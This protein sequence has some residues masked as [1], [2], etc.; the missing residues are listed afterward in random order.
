MAGSWAAVRASAWPSVVAEVV[1]RTASWQVAVSHWRWRFFGRR[2]ALRRT[3]AV[4]AT[5][6][7]GGGCSGRWQRPKRRRPALGREKADPTEVAPADA[8]PLQAVNIG[9]P[10][11]SPPAK[12]LLLANL[13]KDQIP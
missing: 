12:F 2:W 1:R 6:D 10:Q 7:C 4:G 8:G 3:P 13:S 5:E 9:Q 11:Q